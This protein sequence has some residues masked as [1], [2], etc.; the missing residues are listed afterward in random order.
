MS[1]EKIMVEIDEK[2]FIRATA[3][4]LSGPS[5]I[6]GVTKI[7]KDIAVISEIDKTDEFYGKVEIKQASESKINIKR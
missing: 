6:D 3:K 1:E 4:G 2:G 7:L 5:C